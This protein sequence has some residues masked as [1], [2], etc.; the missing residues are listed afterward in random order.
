MRMQ[1][2]VALL[3]NRVHTHEQAMMS[4]LRLQVGVRLEIPDVVG[5]AL[6]IE[7]STTSTGQALRAVADCVLEGL[8]TYQVGQQGSDCQEHRYKQV[9]HTVLSHGARCHCFAYSVCENIHGLAD[10]NHLTVSR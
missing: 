10:V 3:W 9:C 6:V 8:N 5:S 7:E 2:V 4:C 1:A